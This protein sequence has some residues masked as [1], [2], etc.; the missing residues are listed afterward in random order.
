MAGTAYALLFC[1]A[2]G[3]NRTSIVAVVI[4]VDE[5]LIRGEK[6]G[7]S[8]RQ[9]RENQDFGDPSIAG[10]DVLVVAVI[11]NGVSP[12]TAAGSVKNGR[13]NVLAYVSLDLTWLGDPGWAN[14]LIK[15]DPQP[16]AL[17]S[18]VIGRTEVN[19]KK[20]KG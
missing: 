5:N 17:R 7:R 4:V 3:S 12:G 8:G 13:C 19:G 2:T 16:L 9:L 14:S 10:R 18:N 1:A 15:G 20:R 6:D 11:I